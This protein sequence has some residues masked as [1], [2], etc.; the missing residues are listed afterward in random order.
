MDISARGLQKLKNR[1]GFRSK[2]YL[3]SAGKLTVGYGTCIS[4]EK[5]EY[6]KAHPLTEQQAHDLMMPHVKS[7][8]AL[9]GKVVRVPLT[10]NQVDALVSF[11]YNIGEEAFE[12]STMVKKLNA[13]LYSAAAEQFARWVH[14]DNGKVIPGL[15][16]RHASERDQFLG[17]I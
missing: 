7:N 13:R 8:L 12:R 14:D 1:E 5:G 17:K 9:I 2:P 4:K 15:V 10:Q 11:I 16:T 6:Y 3:C